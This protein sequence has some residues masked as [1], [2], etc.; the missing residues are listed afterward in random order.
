M[1]H[2][3]GIDL[4]T[5]NSAI[6]SFSGD[7][8]RIY[9]S[10]EQNDVT[11]SVIFFDR[12]GNKYVGQRAYDAAPGSPGNAARLF[13]RHM[14]TSTPVNLPAV[15]LTKAPEECS[16]EVLKILFGYLSEELRNAEDLGTVITVPAAFNQMQKDATMQAADMAGIGKLALMQEPVAAVMS[17]MRKRN[18]NGIFLIYD[19]GGGTL[20][21]AIAEILGGDVQI[22]THGGIA[23]CGGRDWDRTLVDN[24][25]KPWL[26]GNFDLPDDLT[27]NPDY[28]TLI[29]LAE[30]ATEK[31]KIELSTSESS[32]I[33]LSEAETRVKDRAGNEVYLDI[34]L[35]QKSLNELI[36]NQV[37]ET[38]ESVRETINK[39]GLSASDIERIVFIGGPTNYKPIR[40]K[41]SFEIGIPGSQAVN[42]MTAVA[43]GAALFAESID[44]NSQSRGRKSKVGKLSSHGKI[45]VEFNYTARTPDTQAK[46]TAQVIGEAVGGV[47]F[48]ID[49]LDTGWT[50][51]RHPLND[52]KVIDIP[53]GIKGD[54]IFKAFVFDA[55]NNALTLAQDKIVISRV[56]ATIEAIPASHSI[57]IEVLTKLDGA[58]TLE[59]LVR[60]G[61]SLPSTGCRIFKTVE[62]IKAGSPNSI[63][64]KMW[65]GEIEDKV[66][67]N[68]FIGMF[69]ISGTDF[70]DG[71]IPAGAD[72]ECKYEIRDSGNIWFEAS[73][74]DIG[75]TFQ[76]DHN[77]YS[78]QDGQEDF[79]SAAARIVKDSESTMVD[80][81]EI[82]G[83]IEDVRLDRAREKLSSASAIDPNEQDA[84]RAQEASE[85][86]LQAKLILAE[87]RHE[88][89][90]EIRELELNRIKLLFDSFCREHAR[91]SEKASFD[92]LVRTAQREIDRSSKNF[93]PHRDQLFEKIF[94][95]LW[96]QD[97]F[98][99]QQFKEMAQSP[100]NF[101]DQDQ[102]NKFVEAGKKCLQSDD[103]DT[104]RG[105]VAN[106]GAQQIRPVSELDMLGKVNIVRG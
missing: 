54:N 82:N 53:L 95:I 88:Y 80:L 73:A 19:Y 41:V 92:T 55:A 101:S 61:D 50:S 34:A 67:D 2:Y 12:R 36:E 46:I 8:I 84:E 96:N 27:K 49:S 76:S 103:I 32:V 25:V 83:V 105:I 89:S 94:N 64:L 60:A 69:K 39:A 3:V 63:N 86:I 51:G 78:R 42:P 62:S 15:N 45:D 9:K 85:R 90:K 37:Y 59:W 20:D 33:N 16:A 65:E 70:D 23:M 5:T 56:V 1:K 6:A 75:C 81:D 71:I 97:W 48:Q 7:D 68:R 99:V 58:Q 10:P 72:L 13:K 21:V 100:Y 35:N 4:G 66:I 52:K 102:F 30:W 87:V 106:M 31:A 91:Q 93:E 14:G 98:V 57:G 22:L 17:V 43:E 79:S 18:S 28:E 47:E 104:L 74:P 11:P 24:V 44:F 29:R 77:F 40:E 38:I 26:L